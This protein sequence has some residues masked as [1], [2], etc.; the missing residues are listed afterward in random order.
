L[1]RDSFVGSEEDVELSL[2]QGKQAPVRDLSPA[3]LA[4]GPNVVGGQEKGKGLIEVF[5]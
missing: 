2:R 5:V 3:H 1:V 4:D